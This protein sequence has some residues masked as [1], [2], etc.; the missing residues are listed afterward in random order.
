VIVRIAEWRLSVPGVTWLDLDKTDVST[1]TARFLRQN[2][3]LRGE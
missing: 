2:G 1:V 3:L